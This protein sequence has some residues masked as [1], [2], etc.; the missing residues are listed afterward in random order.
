MASVQGVAGQA[1]RGGAWRGGAALT[2]G[3][4]TRLLCDCAGARALLLRRLGFVNGVSL[5]R[6]FL[7]IAIEEAGV[8]PCALPCPAPARQSV[9]TGITS[10]GRLRPVTT[11]PPVLVF[12]MQWSVS[13]SAQSQL[14]LSLW[15]RSPR[16]SAVLTPHSA[17]RTAKAQCFFLTVSRVIE[18]LDILL[19]QV[20]CQ[21]HTQCLRN[22]YHVEVDSIL[23]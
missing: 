13:V 8:R 21:Y 14:S 15:L 18:G 7:C 11:A 1:G 3:S 22:D 20:S 6:C 19:P 17:Q 16:S 23:K 4:Q 5:F 10:I 9:S 2:F 12:K